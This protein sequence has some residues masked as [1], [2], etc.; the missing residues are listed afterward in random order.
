MKYLITIFLLV[1]NVI[2]SN[3]QD[4]TKLDYQ[5]IYYC[6]EIDGISDFIREFLSCTNPQELQKYIVFPDF[7]ASHRCGGT[8]DI[9]GIRP[10]DSTKIYKSDIEIKE[11][12]KKNGCTNVVV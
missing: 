7:N 4:S 2:E 1:F 9:R 6:E 10:Y 11:M 8:Y 12:L 3:S 5:R